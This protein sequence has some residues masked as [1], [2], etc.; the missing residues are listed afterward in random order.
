MQ[1]EYESLMSKGTWELA[2]LPKDLK[3]VGCKWVFRTKRDA[4]GQVVRYKARLVAKGYSQVEDVDFNETFAPVA[5]FTTIRCLLA[6]GAALDLEMHQMD[7]KT[8]FLNPYL[9]EVIYMDQP[10]GFVQDGQQHLKGKLKKAIYGLRQCGRAWYKDIDATFERDGFTRS[11]ANHSLN[12]KQTSKS[13]LIVIIY[14]DDLIILAS[15]MDMMKGLKFKLEEEYDMSDVGELHFFLGV[16]IERDRAANTI[17]MHQRSYIEEVLKRFGMKDCKSITTPLDVK[18]QLVKLTDEEH[19]GHMQEMQGVSYKEAVGSL[20]YATVATRADIAFAVS[21][22]TQ[23]MSKPSSM[24]WVMVKSILR[25]LKGTLDVK[26]CL[27]G[28]ALT[29]KGYCDADWGGD[30]N[31]RRSTMGYVFFLGQGAISWSS[32]RQPTIALSTTEAEYMAASQSVKEAIWF[33]ELMA[34]VGC[35]QERATMIICDNQGCIAL[36]K[37]PKHH[38]RTKHIDVQHHFIREKVEEEVIELRYC[39]T[40]EMVADVLTKAL[41]RDK[42]EAM[43]RAMRLEA[44]DYSK[45]GV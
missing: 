40:Q 22:V 10:Q 16:H 5:K 15:D 41:T 25:Y 29:L 2:A 13:L 18:A 8:T 4:L 12:I 23:F 27:G 1:E 20:M 26:L 19:E 34:D 11:H 31:S 37:N 45:V 28:M 39:P 7:V 21:V 35:V 24:H 32:K 36:A 44:F 3:S 6:I 42:H 38:S 14:V 43:R 30:V 9:E 33:R 17:T